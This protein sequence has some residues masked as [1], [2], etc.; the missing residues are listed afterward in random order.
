MQYTRTHK[1][2]LRFLSQTSTIIELIHTSTKQQ[3]ILAPLGY[4]THQ[5]QEFP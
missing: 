4:L 2:L 3:Y 1:I 5:L